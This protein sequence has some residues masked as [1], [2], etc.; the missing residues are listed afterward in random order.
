MDTI[1]AYICMDAGSS[2]SFQKLVATNYSQFR[3]SWY[4]LFFQVPWL[5]EFMQRLFDFQAFGTVFKSENITKDDL[6]AFK[7]VFS[8]KGAQTP[9]INYYRANVIDMLL[10]KCALPKPKKFAPGLYLHGEKDFYVDIEV[11]DILKNMFPNLDG[12]VIP[13]ATHFA[14]QDQP[15]ATNK[16]MREFLKKL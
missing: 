8:K 12:K 9:P 15:E 5:P 7:Y 1:E 16:L 2:E 3:K 13:K 14:Q 10:G 11:M 6:E 4:M